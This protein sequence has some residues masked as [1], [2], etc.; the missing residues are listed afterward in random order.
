[1]NKI[2]IVVLISI[3]HAVTSES[4]ETCGN[5]KLHAESFNGTSLI[6]HGDFPW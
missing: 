1:M 5:V 4:V 2:F 6:K 3:G